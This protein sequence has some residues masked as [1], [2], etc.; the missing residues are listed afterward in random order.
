MGT[1]LKSTI[2][3]STHVNVVHVVCNIEKF[4]AYLVSLSCLF[5]LLSSCATSRDM[6]PSR[7]RAILRKREREEERRKRGH[8]K[9][10]N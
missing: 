3:C 4:D 2:A 5:S 6:T 1:L 8:I 7:R 9:N 10:D